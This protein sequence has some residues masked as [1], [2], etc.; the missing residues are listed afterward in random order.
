MED[1]MNHPK[2]PHNQPFNVSA[3][4]TAKRGWWIKGNNIPTKRGEKQ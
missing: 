1:V 2:A 4:H 3:K